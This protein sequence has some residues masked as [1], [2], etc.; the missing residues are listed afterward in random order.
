MLHDGQIPR[1][2]H[3]IVF[4][5]VAV[6]LLSL[7]HHSPRRDC[8]VAMS[9]AL[10]SLVRDN[11]APTTLLVSALLFF[12]YVFVVKPRSLKTALTLA[13]TSAFPF[14]FFYF[15]KASH[16][17][18]DS[19]R[20]SLHNLAGQDYSLFFKYAVFYLPVSGIP[21]RAHPIHSGPQASTAREFVLDRFPRWPTA[22][23]CAF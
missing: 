6:S 8:L 3:P 19:S 10:L 23:L 12:K 9:A 21:P 2:G 14:L 16:T 22:H 13:S 17:D 5:L 11:G 1:F 18:V 20:L 15:C 7:E 4:F